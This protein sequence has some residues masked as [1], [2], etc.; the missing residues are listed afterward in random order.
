MIMLLVKIAIALIISVPATLFSKRLEKSTPVAPPPKQSKKSHQS[1]PLKKRFEKT[2]PAVAL[3]IVAV[4]T[5]ISSSVVD[6]INDIISAP[7]VEVKVDTKKNTEVLITATSSKYLESLA[8]DIP[9]LG[10]I[11]NVQDINSITDGQTIIKQQFT[12]NTRTSQS[13]IEFY[14]KD[15]KLKENLSI[16]FSTNLHRLGCMLL[17]QI[18]IKFHTAGLMGESS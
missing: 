12:N 9:I 13:N 3:S 1:S 5:V 7:T 4:A 10:K 2:K 6:M 15:M 14:I 18:D 8:I 16:K 17:E 11:K